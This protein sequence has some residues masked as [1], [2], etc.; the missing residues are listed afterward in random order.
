MYVT[1]LL[2]SFHTVIKAYSPLVVSIVI[3][4]FISITDETS[5]DFLI[6]FSLVNADAFLRHASV[7][8]LV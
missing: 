7:L 1:L 8:Y 3:H 4:S 5:R 6:R 2:A